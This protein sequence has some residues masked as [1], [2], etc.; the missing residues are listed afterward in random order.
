[1]KKKTVLIV[2]SGGRGHALAWGCLRD[3]RVN[4][5]IMTPGNAGM[6]STDGIECIDKARS[7]EKILTVANQHDV[8]ITIVGAEQYL[9]RGIVNL[10]EQHDRYIIGPTQEASILESSKG[11]TDTLCKEIG[12]R[13]PKFWIFSDPETAKRHIESLPH[14]TVVVKCDGLAEGKGSI[15]CDSKEEAA[16]AIDLVFEMQ[17]AEK[18]GGNTVVI[19]ERLSGMEVTATFLTDGETVVPLPLSRDYKPA[20]DG[21]EGKNTGG[22]GCYS[23]HPWEDLIREK[24]LEMAHRV[25]KGLREKHGI[26]YK[27]FLYLG[28]LFVDGDPNRPVL[29]EINV[30]LGDPETEVIVPRVINFLDVLLACQEQKLAEV[31]LDISPQFFCDVVLAS[32]EVHIPAKADIQ[33]IPEGTLK[34]FRSPALIWSA[35][36]V[37]SFPPALHIT[38]KK[39][40]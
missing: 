34:D 3:P 25:I 24:T 37:S 23:P 4:P 22:M 38:L 9:R 5:V 16:A 2:D 15:V 20:F 29:L 31:K 40:W 39:G 11:F 6:L 7:P 17:A 8:D 28:L 21:D 1:M 33:A 26:T 18:W 12:V 27:G 10:F 32:G 36:T 19:Q 13:V 30:R 35:R 14:D